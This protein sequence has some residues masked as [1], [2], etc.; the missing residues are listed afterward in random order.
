MF[1][2]SPISC[3]LRDQTGAKKK[4]NMWGS[5]QEAGVT[6]EEGDDSSPDSG[7]WRRGWEE[8]QVKSAGLNHKLD[9]GG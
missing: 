3:D 5:S 1:L 7:W 4:T 2:K 9:R 8:I 6:A